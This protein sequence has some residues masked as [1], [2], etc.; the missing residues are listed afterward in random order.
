MI[1][2]LSKLGIE[3]TVELDKEH[4]QIPTANVIFIGETL[5]A[6]ARMSFSYHCFSTSY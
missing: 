6:G 3:K 2:T 1:K 5:V 4:L